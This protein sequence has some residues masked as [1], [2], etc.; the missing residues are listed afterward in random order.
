M[1]IVRIIKC[2]PVLPNSLWRSRI[3]TGKIISP[4]GERDLKLMSLVLSFEY[5]VLL[6]FAVIM[7]S[8]NLPY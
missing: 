7:V 8:K 2:G 1:D 3:Q 6:V 4:E 5:Y